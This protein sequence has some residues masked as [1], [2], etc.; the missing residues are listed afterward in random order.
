MLNWFTIR[1]LRRLKR[2]E[3]SDA[4]LKKHR[5]ELLAFM[6]KHPMQTTP[7]KPFFFMLHAWKPLMAVLLVFA[8]LSG[9]GGAVYAAQ[10]AIPGEAL[11]T[12]KIASEDVREHLT[13]SPEKKM[14]FK[15]VRAERR[16]HEVERLL[17][18]RGV[19]EKRHEQMRFAM[20]KYEDH[21][22]K[23][24]TLAE[25]LSEKGNEEA[26]S[27]ILVM[28]DRIVEKHDKVISSAS[29]SDAISEEV[30]ILP[31]KKPLDLGDRFEEMLREKRKR[32]E[33][34]AER[35]RTLMR[36]KNE[37]LRADYE[38]YRERKRR[39]MEERSEEASRDKRIDT[40]KTP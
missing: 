18:K 32:F 38:R 10:D 13:V 7:A 17:E 24:E 20:G 14:Q 19:K 22:E 29:A 4:V 27:R 16:L 40:R 9:T 31:I 33:A 3:V 6:E 25:N 34:E 5:A 26:G 15:A 30:V 39:L 2:K 23:L 28:I 37:R 12:V 21:L 35:R 36:E 1:K 8:V 11:Y